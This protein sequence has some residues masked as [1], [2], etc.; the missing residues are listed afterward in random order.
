MSGDEKQAEGL[1]AVIV[2]FQP[3]GSVR[4][5][6]AGNVTPTMLW[7]ASALLSRIADDMFAQT[8]AA[9]RERARQTGLSVVRNL[10][11]RPGGP[12]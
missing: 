8:I 7:G 11:K 6:M 4:S 9:A 3:D 1:P 10:P 5:D 12:A 2:T